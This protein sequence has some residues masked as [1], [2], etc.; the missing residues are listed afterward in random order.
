MPLADETVK[1]DFMGATNM[2]KG[3]YDPYGSFFA[4]YYRR[5]ASCL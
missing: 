2:E 4:P 3:I 5:S 1:G